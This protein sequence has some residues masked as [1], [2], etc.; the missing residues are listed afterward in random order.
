[1]RAIYSLFTY[2][3]LSFL[4]SH[5][6]IAVYGVIAGDNIAV[7]GAW[8]VSS[9][10]LQDSF[11]IAYQN[12]K[13]RDS[14]HHEALKFLRNRTIVFVGDSLTRY[15]FLYLIHYIRSGQW[16][17]PFAQKLCCEKEYTN[18]NAFY[19]S[20]AA[21][22]GCSHVCDC[23]GHVFDT[24]GGVSYHHEN[25]YFYDA[26][27]NVHVNFHFWS[28]MHQ[29]RMSYF[30]HSPNADDFRV[31]CRNFTSTTSILLSKQLPLTQKYPNV[32][33]FLRNFIQPI[34]PDALFINH[35]AWDFNHHFNHDHQSILAMSESAHNASHLVIWK[36]TTASHD[37]IPHD[38]KEFL[39]KMQDQLGFQIFD[40]FTLST[41]ISKI[42]GARWDNGHFNGFV[43]RELNIA[44]LEHL[45]IWMNA[46]DE[47]TATK[48][49]KM[50]R[51]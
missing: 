21:T 37:N 16:S 24:T 48:R 15:Q 25:H 36:G 46:T 44:M 7:N 47:K 39:S 9:T 27:L 13:F 33:E 29:V 40:T 22:F 4:F 28:S 31:Y 18:W 49:K 17:D 38:S 32:N 30:N 1:M 35:G 42:P 8:N 50:R 6:S 41:E 10:N 11:L 3:I 43:Y 26:N 2:L 14:Y 45:E 5:H 20:L 23:K 34:L 19:D 12:S 51:L